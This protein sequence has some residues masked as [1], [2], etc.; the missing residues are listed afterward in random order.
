M[1][2]SLSGRR[3][4]RRL[5]LIYAP[6]SDNYPL[7][8]ML[9]KLERLGGGDIRVVAHP[10]CGCAIA[11]VPEAFVV[12]LY[13]CPLLLRKLKLRRREGRV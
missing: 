4:Q 13:S 1:K 3:R 8:S 5:L 10:L 6:Q 2:L 12:H 11:D 9:K 7:R